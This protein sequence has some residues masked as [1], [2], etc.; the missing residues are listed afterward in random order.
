MESGRIAFLRRSVLFFSIIFFILF[1]GIGEVIS[2]FG[3]CTQSSTC[4]FSPLQ[5]TSYTPAIVQFQ[6]IKDYVS[7]YGSPDCFFLGH[8]LVQTGINPAI[9]ATTFQ[10]KTGKPIRCYNAAMDGAS[11]S[12]TAPMALILS[13]LYHPTYLIVG[14]QANSFFLISDTIPSHVAEGH[15]QQDSWIQYKLGQFNLQGWLIDNSILYNALERYLPPLFPAQQTG[16]APA[17]GSRPL[18][19][20]V[21]H[22]TDETGYGPL[23]GYRD[24]SPLFQS[25][26]NFYDTQSLDPQ[27]F[28]A[29]DQIINH[30]QKGEF[31][32]AFVQMP[33]NLPST[34][35][36]STINQVRERSL[37][38][39]IPF[40]STDGL[41]PLPTTAYADQAHMQISGSYQFSAWLGAQFGEAVSS[42]ALSDVNSPLWSPIM[43]EW[44]KPGY[45]ATLGLSNKSYAEYIKYADKFDLLPPD[46]TIFNP[47]EPVVDRTFAQTLL[48]FVADWKAGISQDERMKVFQLMTILGKMRYQNELQLSPTQVQQLDQWR[49]VPDAAILSELRIHYLICREER[50]KPNTTYCPPGIIGNPNYLDIGSWDFP[51]LYERYHL[52]QVGKATS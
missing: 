35:V 9:F 51:P 40:L 15:F 38:Q 17:P 28:A 29:F 46:A 42:G 48:G 27:D 39:G 4:G 26:N 5:Q 43:K 22:M 23:P 24:T 36:K 19:P 37:K 50:F 16:P 25:F 47:V 45:T 49:K 33:I 30:A 41:V 32:L 12:S 14:L 21:P 34:L 10:T 31:Q 8:S 44:P 11:M 1:T 3:F 52:Y 7:R 20:D 18:H 6:H 2:R 13:K